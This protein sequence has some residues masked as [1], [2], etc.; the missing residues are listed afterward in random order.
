MYKFVMLQGS[1]GSPYNVNKAEQTANNMLKEGYE[2]SH[3]YQSTTSGCGGA[4]SVLVMVFRKRQVA[5]TP[6]GTNT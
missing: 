1:C 2:L 6:A 5:K 3:V 4:Q